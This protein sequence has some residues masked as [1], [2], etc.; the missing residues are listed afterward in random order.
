MRAAI[1]NLAAILLTAI[2]GVVI[3]RLLGRDPHVR[4]CVIA[5]VALLVATQ[6]SM[7][8]LILTRGAGH[9]AVAQAGLVATMIHL[10]V[11]TTVAAIVILGHMPLGQPFLYWLLAFYWMTLIVVAAECVAAV[12]RAVP[13]PSTKP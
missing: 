11:A 1:L 13:E 8:P 3:F 10:M 4:E 7:I 5:G 6:M 12:K 2:G 9:L